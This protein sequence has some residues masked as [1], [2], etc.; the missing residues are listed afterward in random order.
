MFRKWR[1][2]IGFIAIAVVIPLV[3]AGLKLDQKATLLNLIQSFSM[4]PQTAGN[5]FNGYF[6]TRFVLNGLWIH[7]PFLISLVAGDMLA[8]EA[9]AGTFRLLLTRPPSRTALFLA[10]LTATFVY[11]ALLVLFLGAPSLGMGLLLF[12]SGP[13]LV[14][15][16][17]LTFIPEAE[18][19][20]RLALAFGLAVAAMWCVAAL[21]LLFSACTENAIG[22]IVGSMAVVIIFLVLSTLPVSLFVT[23]RPWLFSTHMNVWHFAVSNPVPWG[24][25]ARSLGVLAV[26]I[27]L[28]C[29][30]AWA[31][32]VRKDIMS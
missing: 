11:T 25:L 31:V 3:E 1:T 21:G 14:P 27:V 7:I 20:W 23:V 26:Y 19:P 18:A 2:Y 17:P 6:V 16:T 24:E 32:M 8:G 29:G 22:P 10:K 15:G 28:F 5:I 12:G 4:M 9:A 30:A 13:L